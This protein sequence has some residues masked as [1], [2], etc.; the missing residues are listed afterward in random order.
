M[1][2]IDLIVNCLN[3]RSI[4]LV[5]SKTVKGS[6]IIQCV[7]HQGESEPLKCRLVIGDSQRS[8]KVKLKVTACHQVKNHGSLI[9]VHG[10]YRVTYSKVTCVTYSNVTGG[11]K[12]PRVTKSKVTKG[13]QIKGYQD[14]HQLEFQFGIKIG[15]KNVYDLNMSGSKVTHANIQPTMSAFP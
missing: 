8:L 3:L 14:T 6:N 15:S 11:Q 9:I 2:I 10:H 4:L 13:H 1:F 5:G 7:F 12:S